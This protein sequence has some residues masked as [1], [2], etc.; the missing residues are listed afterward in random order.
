MIKTPRDLK[1]YKHNLKQAL[2]NTFLRTTLDT[3]ASAYPASRASAF[4]EID[5][6]RLA[7]EIAKAK[8]ESIPNLEKLLE[9]F[10]V[11]AKEAGV[12]VHFARTAFEANSIIASIARDNGVK[13]DR[14]GQ[15]DD[16]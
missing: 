4:A 2:G 5:F 8:D 7:S 12:T 13:T 3:F 1:A 14:Q 11:R 15:V 16:C 9:E 10:T 6:D